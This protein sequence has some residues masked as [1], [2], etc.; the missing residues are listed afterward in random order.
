MKLK[1][2]IIFIFI[3][4]IDLRVRAIDVSLSKSVIETPENCVEEA[5]NYC[6]IKNLNKK[7][8]LE[9]EDYYM[10]LAPQ[11]IVIKQ[12]TRE[13]SLV[14]GQVFVKSVNNIIFEVPYGQIEIEKGSQIVL[15]KMSDKVVIQTIF[16]KAYLK[17]LGEKKP[18][19]VMAGQENFI[20]Q[21]DEA[22]K[23]QTGIPKPIL[24]APLLKTWALHTNVKK[25]EFINE[26]DAFKSVHEKAVQ[27]LSI[28]N[29]Q[30]ATR[31]IASAKAE[32]LAREEQARRAKEARK[33]Q[34]ETYYNRLLSE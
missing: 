17:P 3:F 4:T 5:L 8:S 20:S 26:V 7:F 25:Q 32:K 27:E 31:E 14:K 9:R 13:F 23:A 1:H 28:L 33:K 11:A 22:S 12:K 10:S 21:V 34:Q 15:E 18:I 30:I 6:I 16:G 19:V 2:V 24:V 29:E